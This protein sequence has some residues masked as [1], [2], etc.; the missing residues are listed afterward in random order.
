MAIAEPV[1]LALATTCLL[2]RWFSLRRKFAS[3]LR[4]LDSLLLALLVPTRLSPARLL[5][6]VLPDLVHGLPGEL[7][8]VGVHGHVNDPQVDADHVDRP[9][10]GPLR[11]VDRAQQV[12]LALP[13]DRGRPDP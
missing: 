13:V 7:I 3:R 11:H 4:I 6:V 9:D 12:E 2:I 10:R 5:G 8:A 1:A